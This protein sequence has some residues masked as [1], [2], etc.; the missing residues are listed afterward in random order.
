MKNIFLI[1][2]LFFLCSCGYTSVYKN[3]K[4][5]DLQIVISETQGDKEMNNL[6]SSEINLYSNKN[7]LERFDVAIQT[8]YNKSILGKNISGN[9]TDYRL[10]VN[11][12]FIV[13]FDQ[14]SKKLTFSEKI[15]IKNRTDTFE[16]DSYEK[17]IR[18]NFASS[19]REKLISEIITIRYGD[20]VVTTK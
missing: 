17:N 18:R 10:S 5:R 7:S 2:L 19:L 16:Q 13:Y 12:T 1:S 4:N 9:T 3:I 11:S 6:L 8:K 14:N 20:G 15:N